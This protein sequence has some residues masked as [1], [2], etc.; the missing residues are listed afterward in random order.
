[1]SIQ[2]QRNLHIGIACN[3]F[4]ENGNDQAIEKD[5]MSIGFGIEQALKERGYRISFFDF[6]NLPKAFSDLKK[7]EVDLVFNVC[8][9]IND[10]SLLE[11]HAAA[12]LDTLQIPYTGSNP[13]TLALCID[14]IR[15]KK[16]LSFHNIPTPKWDY[17]YTLE[18]EIDE[19]LRYPLIIKPGNTDNSIGITNESVVTNKAE[20]K[21]QLEKT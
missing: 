5:L 7:S 1:M 11:P 20:L 4:E 12:I 10:S 16:L 14:K 21:K 18:D 13:F 8:E 3:I 15:V 2:N 17:A 9:R 19:D 6:N